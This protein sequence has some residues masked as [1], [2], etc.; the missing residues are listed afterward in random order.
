MLKPKRAKV[1]LFAR[2]HYSRSD[3]IR[4]ELE[5]GDDAWKKE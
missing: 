1:A 3:P 5:N 4:L 2:G